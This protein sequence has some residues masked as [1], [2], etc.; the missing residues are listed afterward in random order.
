M[1][2]YGLAFY[3]Q[4]TEQVLVSPC[5]NL[6]S[7]GFVNYLTAL[8][9]APIKYDQNAFPADLDKVAYQLLDRLVHSNHTF[10]FY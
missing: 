9:D 10:K 6:A 7:I 3:D 2:Y 4:L 1:I 5:S 8:K